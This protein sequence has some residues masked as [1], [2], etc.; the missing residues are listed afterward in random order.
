[1]HTRA[2]TTP[3][4]TDEA[5]PSRRA[6]QTRAHGTAS[7]H[8][9]DPQIRA[10]DDAKLPPR[11]CARRKHASRNLPAAQAAT[12]PGPAA[13]EP[14]VSSCLPPPPLPRLPAPH[15]TRPRGRTGGGTGAPAS[16]PCHAY[17][18]SRNGGRA[19][20]GTGTACPWCGGWVSTPGTALIP[21]APPRYAGS[22]AARGVPGPRAK[23]QEDQAPRPGPGPRE[24]RQAREAR[25]TRADVVRASPYQCC[26]PSWKCAER[27][28]GGAGE[29]RERC[30]ISHGAAAAVG[31][32]AGAHADAG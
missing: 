27:G 7:K 10:Q 4:T 1:M 21:H 19:E 15:T 9:A 16:R 5:A 25:R 31:G 29:K 24:R 6:A 28:G 3:P 20:D 30:M 23:G 18:P 32:G 13:D 26:R 14:L 8:R 11:R 17:A 12:S 2:S 22:R